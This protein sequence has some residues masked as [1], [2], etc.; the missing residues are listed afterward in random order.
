[1]KPAAETAAVLPNGTTQQYLGPN[2]DL[3]D[4]N[5]LNLVLVCT[6]KYYLEVLNKEK[7]ADTKHV[8][9]FEAVN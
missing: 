3:F 8:F 9:N 5:G 1:M 4:P 6:S 7:N 2:S